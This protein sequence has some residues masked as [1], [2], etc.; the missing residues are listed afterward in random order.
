MFDQILS[1]LVT[2]VGE[3][4]LNLLAG[5]GILFVGWIIARIVKAVVFRLVKRTKLDERLAGAVSDEG[6]PTKLHLGKWIST[7][8]FY[9][10]MLFVLVAFFQT[11]QLPAVAEPLNAMLGQI[12]LAAPQF[13][14][15]ILILFVAWLVATVAKFVIQRTMRMTKL[16]EKL[17]D[18]AEIEE[19]N[20]SD[21]L[22]NGVFWLV[23]LL[24]LPAVLNALG[25]QGL[26]E[27]VTG[28]VDTI[29]G[30]I[31]NIFGAAISLFVGW[32][33]ARIVRQVV[34]N[35]LATT[36]LDSFGER[37]GV[38]GAD[39]P[40]SLSRLIGSVVYILILIPAFISALNT[41]GVEAI[42]GPAILMLTTVMNGIPLFFGA[43][44][45]L[46]VAYFAGKLVSGLVSNLLTG[47][48]FDNIPEAL[49]LQATADKDQRSLSE[50][51]GYI[52]LVAILLL[53]G[54][55]AA[56]MIGFT[57]LS[58]M[59]ANFTSFGGQVL[60]ALVIFGIGLYLANLA[61]KVVL[62]AGGKNAGL[63]SSLVR[64]AIL[65]FVAAMALQQVGV[66]SEIINIAF[67][68]LLGALGV[69]LALAFGLGSR[70]AAARLVAGWVKDLEAGEGEGKRE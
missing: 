66:A 45:I 1:Q 32:L 55:E 17:A 62:A 64:G 54:I 53:A 42:S 28:V 41:L 29:L 50:V 23:F 7:A 34:V 60:L 35:L 18:H 11:V 9:L 33:I 68:V 58:S 70:D 21:L 30:A 10:V 46:V 19:V 44:L 61:N 65:V 4:M 27:P 24:F 36:N 56:D 25:M 12:A 20:A 22:A 15:A 26:V 31:P 2:L 13:L 38:S 52:A 67:G 6:E 3:D 16:D 47:I 39:Q 14:G 8:A 63:M 69:A 49:G 57:F 37:I 59:L 51:A 43:V 40:Q 48:G 5:L